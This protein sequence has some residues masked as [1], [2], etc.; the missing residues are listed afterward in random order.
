MKKSCLLLLALCVSLFTLANP[1]D[2]VTANSVAKKFF[3]SKIEVDCNALGLH[4]TQSE[5]EVDMTLVYEPSTESDASEYYVFAPS[6]AEG[7]VIVSGEDT[8]EPIIG[9]SLNGNFATEQMPPAFEHLLSSYAEYV[10]DV[11]AGKAAPIART[12]KTVVPVP[13]LITT[14]WNQHTPYNSYCPER[15]GKLTIAGCVPIALAQ[16]MKYYEWPKAGHGTCTATIYPST[17]VSITLGEEY[18]WKN[19]LDD[20]NGVSYTDAEAKAV[21]LLVRD[22]GYACGARYSE[23][24]TAA[25]NADALGALVDNFDYSFST[26]IINRNYYPEEKWEDVLYEELSSGRPIYC[27]GPHIKTGEGHAFVCCGIDESGAYYINFGWGSGWDAYFHLADM[28]YSVGEAIVGIRPKKDSESEDTYVPIPHVGMF[29][30]TKSDNSLSSPSVSCFVSLMNA[31]PRVISGQMGYALLEDEKMISPEINVLQD[32]LNLSVNSSSKNTADL[33]FS[34]VVSLSQGIREI[35]FFWR[36]EESTEW[37]DVMGEQCLY[38]KT[39]ANAHFFFTKREDAEIED[40]PIIPDT[41]IE[42]G[43]YYLKN[44]ATGKFLTAGNDWGTRASI[45]ERGLDIEITQLPNGRYTIDTQI[46]TEEDKHFLGLDGQGSLYMDIAA[47]EWSIGILDNGNY[48]FSTYIP[49]YMAFNEGTVVDL[50]VTN[51]IEDEKAQ[52]Q[53]IRQEELVPNLDDASADNPV[54]ATFFISGASFGVGDARNGRWEGEPT[55]DAANCAQKWN[56]SAFDVNQ[57]ITGLP[58]G[59][60]ELRVQ[61]FYR[62]GGSKTADIA[63]SNYA[64]GK[65]VLNAI[66]YANEETTPLKSIMS[67]AKEGDAP[68]NNNYCTTSLGYVP[69]MTGGASA[70]FGEGLYQH[71]LPVEVTDGTLHIGVRKST[72][73]AYDWTCF[74][75]FELYYYG[76]SLLI[77]EYTVTFYDWDGTELKTETVHKGQDATAPADPV[78]EGYTFTGWDKAFTNVQ[79]DLNVYAVYTQNSSPA[80]TIEL[81]A[82]ANGWV[83]GT[84]WYDQTEKI[85][86]YASPLYRAQDGKVET[87]RF[88]VNRTKGNTKYFC[89]SELEFYD[90]DGN[91]IVLAASNVASNADHNALNPNA[92]DGGGFAAL[93]DGQ[94]STY[95]HSAWKNMPAEDH[96]LEITLPN[97]GYDAFSF[98]MLSRGRSFENGREND[99]S[100]T[101]PG[102]MV[103]TTSVALVVADNPEPDPQPELDNEMLYHVAQPHHEQGA[104]SWAVTP[105]GSR[106][107][108]NVELDITADEKDSRQQFSFI[109]ND[110][111][112][113]RYLFHPAEQKYVNKDGSLGTIPQDAIYFKSGAYANTFVAYFDDAHFVNVNQYRAL[114]VN[115]W[116]PGGRIGLADGGNSC[117][118]TPVKQTLEP[119][120]TVIFCDWDGTVLK[121][122]TVKWGQDATAP[123]DPIREGYTFTGWDKVFT[124][125]QSDLTVNAVYAQNSVEPKPDLDNDAVYYVSQPYNGGTSWAI[126]TGGS[127]MNINT[128]LGITA[129]S[130]DARQ[131]FAFITNDGG[132]THYLYHP[133]EKKYVNK[134]NTLSATPRDPVYFLAGEYENTFVVYFDESHII[135]TNSTDGLI[136][137]RWGPLSGWGKADGGNSCLITRVEKSEPEPDPDP[138]PELDNETLYFVSQP[139]RGAT[140]WAIAKGGTALQCNGELGLVAD[141]NDTRQQFAFISNDGGKTRYLYHPAER[142]YVN[143]DGSLNATPQN[144]VYFMAGAYENTFVVYFDIYH[145]INVNENPMLVIN[146]WGPAD[147]GWRGTADGGNS[148]KITAVG[149]FTDIDFLLGE[150]LG[151]VRK[152]FENGE[153]FILLPDGSKYTVTG[154]RIK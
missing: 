91:K 62:E 141:K 122:E 8:M 95:F 22:V 111:G 38:M 51:P 32:N 80:Y 4:R 67:E 90:A 30:I 21:G 66:L 97:G 56:V 5:M 52:W 46:G 142:K 105:G 98:K 45:D 106:L 13:P 132:N 123:T 96:Y 60:Y 109:S 131:Q 84:E 75:N 85:V 120:Y 133:A 40:I 121:A 19:M 136:I 130:A 3:Q 79:S 31:T 58:N 42:E 28:P 18:D 70:F 154:V 57:T 108:T 55:I 118:I 78:R 88:T 104:T 115:D 129:N 54:D 69:Q 26:H 20:Y 29:A 135:N 76:T 137:N 9:Y 59:F 125:V 27:S 145:F 44:V 103:M 15:N 14:A 63:A 92:P 24:A 11:R 47:T 77:P 152:V 33:T 86:K 2:M 112:K 74:D 6:D 150:G 1:V 149:R 73:A 43:T 134:D 138:Q 37:Y 147:N 64:A 93:F 87:L 128:K 126:A 35:R 114:V 82:G 100:H 36:P 65:S 12:K 81:N 144:P 23:T 71:A 53:L 151:Y 148:C 34:D 10:D 68:D 143:M 7:F 25:Y 41:D 113:T 94:T 83:D 140:S 72:G 116:G 102:V 48:V 17:K 127:A 146:Q 110:G 119:E 107:Q 153:M 124:N 16:I 89:L 50:S 101:F 49:S 99:Q 39:T 61:G 117:T 139:Y